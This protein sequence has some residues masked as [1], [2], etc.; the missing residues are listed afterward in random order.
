M[1]NTKKVTHIYN[2][3]D[4]KKRRRISTVS[5]KNFNDEQYKIIK[6][7]IKKH[8]NFFI[9]ETGDKNHLIL[10]KEQTLTLKH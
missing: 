3:A 4:W 7:F 10:C 5:I 6:M 1:D 9:C 2:I 8:S